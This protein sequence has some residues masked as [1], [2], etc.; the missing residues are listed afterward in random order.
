L[1]ERFAAWESDNRE[2]SRLDRRLS[3]WSL[4]K[5]GWWKR[6]FE[7]L[8]EPQPD[9]YFAARS[10]NEP[11][12]VS[13]G[14]LFDVSSGHMI[15][16]GLTDPSDLTSRLRPTVLKVAEVNNEYS[17]YRGICIFIFLLILC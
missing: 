10:S 5:K 1:V 2:Y 6:L 8:V 3:S 16:E 9:L 15:A 11:G 12:E 7:K 14:D 17:P 4:L 13:R